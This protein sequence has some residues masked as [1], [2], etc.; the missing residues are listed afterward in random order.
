M[1]YA[2]LKLLHQSAVALSVTGFAI[3]GLASFAGA[4][5][6]GG[7]LARTV[8]HVVDTV[9][10][11]SG[12]TMAWMLRLSPGHAPWLAAKLIGLVM[13][14]VLGVVALRDGRPRPL[15]MTFW[16]AALATVAWIASVAITKDPLGY[17]RPL[18]HTLS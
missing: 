2:T 13:Y 1:D 16:L 6:V 5:W 14:V 7:R 17:F 11:A 18:L 15:R 4:A 8:P 10:L 3:R 12:I 9:L